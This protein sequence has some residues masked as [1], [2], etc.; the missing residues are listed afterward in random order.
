M[1]RYSLSSLP[2]LITVD[3]ISSAII[4]IELTDQRTASVWKNHFQSIKN[5]GFLAQGVTSDNGT[6]LCAAQEVIFADVAWQLDTFHGIAHRLGDWCR[7][8]EKSAYTAIENEQQRYRVLDSAVSDD[9]I[10][11]RIDSYL[12][13]CEKAKQAIDLYELFTYLYKILIEQ[14][15]VFDSNGHQR[16]CCDVK[17]TME[18][19]LE[20]MVSL[21]HKSIIKEVH[22]IQKALPDLLS[23]L[24]E[25]DIALKNCQ[26]LSTNEDALQALYLAWQFHLAVIKSKVCS[27]KH[28]AIAERDFY[29]ELAALFIDDKD[30]YTTLK[31]Q[32]YAELDMIVQAS[33]MV[34]CINSILRPYLTNSKNQITQS[35]LNTFMF[36]HNHRRYH[37]GKRKGKTPMEIL[38]GQPQTEDWIALLLKEIEPKE[39][40][41]LL[42]A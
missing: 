8:L 23:Y 24:D 20:L 21:G 41:C 25:V 29:L 4:R 10:D 28:N 27:R 3:P 15:N 19:V 31:E 26:K 40:T 38:T 2:I 6:G 33:S 11:S 35:F 1:M 12:V 32:V 17:E 34:E 42:T 30:V 37:A 7:R 5:N 18:I 14:L 13:A 16:L 39:Q 36:Y 22:S 9:V